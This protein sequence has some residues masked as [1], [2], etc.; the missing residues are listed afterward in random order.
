MIKAP[1]ENVENLSQLLACY[2]HQDWPEEF[3]SWEDVVNALLKAE[4][5]A[6]VE[7]AAAELD[8]L[9]A[10]EW[11]E[12]DWRDFLI[13]ILCCYVEPSSFGLGYISWLTQLWERLA[14]G[15]RRR[16]SPMKTLPGKSELISMISRLMNADGTEEELD[17]LLISL[18]EL[19]S[20]DVSDLIFYPQ[21]DY[22]AEE[23]ADAIERVEPLS[24]R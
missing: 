15:P 16:N 9:L 13:R 19:A 20:L 17:H 7:A 2:F 18:K 23:I 8:D 21:K 22:S 1:E 14:N 6:T 10:Q 24:T 4:P 12:D 11:T 3:A 5:A